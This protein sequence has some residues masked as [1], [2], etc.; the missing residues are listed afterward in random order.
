VIPAGFR[1]GVIESSFDLGR[2]PTVYRFE[3]PSLP[4][5]PILTTVEPGL[6]V[7]REAAI[8]ALHA[9]ITHY[10]DEDWNIL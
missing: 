2:G 7:N 1:E 8:V 5:L 3:H 4:G 6:P 9:Q 10:S